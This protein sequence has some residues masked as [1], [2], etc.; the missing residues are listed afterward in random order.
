MLWKNIWITL[1]V[2]LSWSQE[3][4]ANTGIGVEQ[5]EGSQSFISAHSLL[6]KHKP[7]LRY[8]SGHARLRLGKNSGVAIRSNGGIPVFTIADYLK[9]N[10]GF[11]ASMEF[12][13]TEV[14]WLKGSER[15]FYNLMPGGG[16]GFFARQGDLSIDMTVKGGYTVT[17]L[18]TRKLLDPDS[19]KYRGYQALVFIDDKIGFSYDKYFVRDFESMAFSVHLNLHKGQEIIYRQEENSYDSVGKKQMM[20]LNLEW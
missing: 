2:L 1:I 12:G 7:D 18:Y 13:N 10:A 14:Q 8:G 4:E 3:T 17:N 6:F 15:N 5:V 11:F 16:A 19:Y 20:L 9:G